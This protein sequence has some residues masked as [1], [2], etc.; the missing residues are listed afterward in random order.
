M[1]RESNEQ[2]LKEVIDRLLKVYKLESKLGE[3][4]VV[5]RWG[6]IV[7]PTIAKH[8]RE[9]FIKNKTLHIRLDSSVVRSELHHGRSKLITLINEYTGKEVINEVILK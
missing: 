7:G 2:S 8:T 4:E 6:E 9:I 5:D 3:H 1:K